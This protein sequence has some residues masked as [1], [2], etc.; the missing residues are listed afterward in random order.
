MKS[1][2]GFGMQIDRAGLELARRFDLFPSGLESY[3]VVHPL[4]NEVARGRIETTMLGH[5]V[6]YLRFNCEQAFCGFRVCTG[7]APDRFVFPFHLSRDPVAVG[8]QG[9]REPILLSRTDSFI[10]GPSVVGVQTIRRATVTHEICLLAD[11]ALVDSCFADSRRTLP[12][13]LKRGFA[14]RE[15]EPF[16]LPGSTN[17]SMGLALRQMMTCGLHGGLARLY[18]EAKVIEIIAMRL[19]QVTGREFPDGSHALMKRDIA[20]LE[21][22]RHILLSLQDRPPT[23]SELARTVGLSRTKLKVGFRIHFGSTV[24]GVLRSHRMQMALELMR[25]GVCN[26]TE[27]AHIVGYNSSGAFATAFKAEYGYPPHLARRQK[28]STLQPVTRS[29]SR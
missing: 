14:K 24:F 1:S 25:D 7:P 23:I 22:A 29:V 27:A 4:P 3:Q 28:T 19:A 16:V 9:E 8:V 10:L 11:S 17:G 21:E 12:A 26:V 18:L 6:G 2:T 5:G 15:G 20:S 13:V